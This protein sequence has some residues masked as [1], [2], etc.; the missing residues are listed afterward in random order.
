M[1]QT[2]REGDHRPVAIRYSPESNFTLEFED[3]AAQVGISIP[4]R[5][6]D[7]RTQASNVKCD[8]IDRYEPSNMKKTRSIFPFEYLLDFMRFLRNS[9]RI[10]VLTYDDFYWESGL[11]KTGIYQEELRVWEFRKR[12]HK[13]LSKKINLIIQFDVDSSPEIAERFTAKMIEIG[14]PANIMLFNK[15]I[16]RKLLNQVG[17]VEE[18]EYPIDDPLYLKARANGFVIGYHTNAV[19]R[20]KHDLNN[21]VKIFRQDLADLRRRF[22]G[23]R[24]FSPHGGVRSAS[25]LNNNDLPFDEVANAE[26]G[27]FWVHNRNSPS[28]TRYFSDGGILSRAN[29]PNRINMR[30]A[31]KK[32]RV[33]NRYRVLLH[34]QYYGGDTPD[35]REV[36]KLLMAQENHKEIWDAYEG[37]PMSSPFASSQ[38]DASPGDS[39]SDYWSSLEFNEE[40]GGFV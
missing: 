11:S 4:K 15:S 29:D 7:R 27:T 18:R 9:D 39:V 20:A 25:G 5:E 13:N 31:V 16:D 35:P 3:R 38:S 33:G 21:A 23:L 26:L 17:D 24:F 32:W 12:K 19:E 34:P 14:V 8:L 1:L 2:M 6:S 36:A 22:P 10:N 40:V 30:S 28:F 37:L